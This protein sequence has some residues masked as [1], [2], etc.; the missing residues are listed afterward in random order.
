MK[1]VVIVGGVAG[2]ASCAA[3]LRRLDEMAKITMIER[4]PYVS[5]ANCGLPYQL[6]GVIEER[7]KLL[8]HTPKTLWD[9]FRIKALTENTVTAI[10]RVS[11]SVE[12]RDNLKQ[13]SFTLSYDFLVLSPGASPVIL[14][15][16]GN[17]LPGIFTLR[18]IEDLDN[19]KKFIE[20]NR[21]KTAL[22]VGAGFVGIEVAENFVHLGIETTILE[23]TSQLMPLLDIEISRYLSNEL[24]ANGVKLL[25]NAGAFKVE[26]LEKQKKKIHLDTGSFVETDL[27]IF[28]VGVRPELDLAKSSGLEIGKLGGIKVDNQ[29]R[30]SDPNIFAIGDAV[31]ITDNIT[32]SP[33]KVQLA[34]PANRQGRLVADVIC[35]RSSVYP[36]GLG[37]SILRA[38]GLTV[39]SVGLTEKRAKQLNID[40]RVAQVVSSDHA[41]YYPDVKQL[42]I[43][44]I[45]SPDGKVLGAQA[46]GTGGVDKRI[47]VLATAIFSRLTVMDLQYLDLAYAPIFSSAKDPVNHLATLATAILD[48]SHPTISITEFEKEVMINK[49]IQLIDVRNKEEFQDGSIANA[50][51]IPVNEIRERMLEI[52]QE[53][54]VIVFCRVGVRAFLATR[55]LMQNG[56]SVRNLMGGYSLYRAKFLPIVEE[57]NGKTFIIP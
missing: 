25:L 54:P 5:F 31:E 21:V 7:D 16:P 51:S 52:S 42:M 37:T 11:K 4:G 29:M 6:G 9:R 13:E 26:Q 27:I 33:T 10:D 23:K 28:G 49:D 32:K 20:R 40:H 48:G 53:K 22:I 41:I 39:A 47:D 43:K 12:V 34:G 8:L 19:I 3:R 1:R 46:V 56:Y 36:G 14:N 24:R 18:T 57:F 30:T 2:G 17:N 15:I 45:F 44:A 50:I 55:I 35:G 38:F